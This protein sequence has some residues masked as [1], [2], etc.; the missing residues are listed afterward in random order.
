MSGYVVGA[1]P[2]ALSILLFLINPS[3]MQQSFNALCGQSMFFVAFLLVGIAF[4][5]I[6]RIVALEV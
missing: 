2:F 4:I 3:Y 5:L 6:R 1:L